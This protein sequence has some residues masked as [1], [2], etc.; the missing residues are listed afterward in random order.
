MLIRYPGGK[1]KLRKQIL[2]YFPYEMTCPLVA[3]SA[4]WS[5]HEPFMGSG[6]MA[7]TLMEDLPPSTRIFLS[8][9]DYHLI[10][11]WQSVKNCPDELIGKIRSFTPAAA[12]FYEFKEQDGSRDMD[13]VRAG[14]QKLA[15]HRM[16]FSGLG[17]MAGGPL[18]GRNQNSDLYR[19]DCRWNVNRICRLVLKI[20]KLMSK[21]DCLDISTGSFDKNLAKM[22]SR[23][24]AYLDPPYYVKG[25]ELYRYS[26]DDAMHL[27]L[28]DVL[29]ISPGHWV[30][31]YDD[32]PIIREL[33]SGYCGIVD[34][35]A[36]YSVH[37]GQK[38]KPKNREILISPEIRKVKIAV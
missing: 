2:K 19:V 35:E 14:F 10:C 3:Q 30:L 36:S 15:L 8:D 29:M 32:A 31:S 38:G 37:S 18:G 34:V 1:G 17:Y 22:T 12:K 6:E 7:F 9:V 28:R 4:R 21:F 23:S 33:Y 13:P 16:S 26:M 24:F 11:L 25:P 20:H 27:K 5:Y